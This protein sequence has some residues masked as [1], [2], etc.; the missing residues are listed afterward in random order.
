MTTN[1]IIFFL[2]GLLFGL[3][4]LF[5]WKYEHLDLIS[6]Y[7]PNKVK[8]KKGL[9]KW[10]GQIMAII[11]TLAFSLSIA[12]SFFNSFEMDIFSYSCFFIVSTVLTITVTIGRKKYY[13]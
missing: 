13:E 6:G 8:D 4:S 12:N 5:I 11:A 1:I 10:Y 7:D 3:L 9:A 2:I